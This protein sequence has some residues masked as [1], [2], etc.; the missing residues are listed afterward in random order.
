MSIGVHVLL[1]SREKTVVFRIFFEK[2]G[3]GHRRRQ[4]GPKSN[5]G[6]C[7]EA[8]EIHPKEVL[9]TCKFKTRF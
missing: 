8:L 9:R 2:K 7:F 6:C 3:I 4:N 5:A 1:Q